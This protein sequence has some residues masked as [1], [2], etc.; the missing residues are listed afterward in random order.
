MSQTRTSLILLGALIAL[1]GCS[2]EPKS[3]SSPA[4]PNSAVATPAAT[5]ATRPPQEIA[6]IRECLAVGLR[7]SI[8]MELE[9]KAIVAS[10]SRGKLTNDSGRLSDFRASFSSSSASLKKL[11]TLGPT[12]HLKA[13]AKILDDAR[14]KQATDCS[15]LTNGLMHEEGVGLMIIEFAKISFQAS[16]YQEADRKAGEHLK[17]NWQNLLNLPPQQKAALQEILETE[18]QLQQVIIE[19]NKDAELKSVQKAAIADVI[20]ELETRAQKAAA[21][22]T[23]ERFYETLIGYQFRPNAGRLEAGEM[24]KLVIKEQK[25]VGHCIVSVI[26]LDLRGNRSGQTASLEL[27]VV[28]K[29]YADGRPVRLQVTLQ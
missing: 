4:A 15:R 23:P 16:N 12:A 13:F 26:H 29:T 19:L 8:L 7:P 6:F 21:G 10:G 28:H 25:I 24:V 20:K 27:S 11:S 22:L 14:A 2:K 1:G 5:Q 3:A 9:S 18:Q 17:Q